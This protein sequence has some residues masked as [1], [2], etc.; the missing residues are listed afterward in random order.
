MPRFW[1]NRFSFLAC[2]SPY[3]IYDLLDVFQHVEFA[4]PQT[5]IAVSTLMQSLAPLNS[6]A[7]PVI[8]CLY[9]RREILRGLYR[10]QRTLRRRA[11]KAKPTV[12]RNYSFPSA[13]QRPS[14]W[15][16]LPKDS[17]ID[18][19]VPP[20]SAMSIK[21]CANGSTAITR[22]DSR[23]SRPDSRD[24]VERTNSSTRFPLVSLPFTQSTHLSNKVVYD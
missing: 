21:C 8:S 4:D 6:V 9:L 15:N 10:I 7:N 24:G 3:C 13:C 14:E 5:K 18:M 22:E 12:T 19:A 1:L 20:N 16:N 11:K 2:W 23:L 17:F